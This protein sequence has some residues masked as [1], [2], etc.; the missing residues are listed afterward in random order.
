[1]ISPPWSI[2]IPIGAV[3]LTLAMLCAGRL[4]EAA[5]PPLRIAVD[6]G[7]SIAAPGAMS[8]RGRVEH[9]F[10]REL[11]REIVDALE[12]IDV[13]AFLVGDRGDMDQLMQDR[14][15]TRLNSSHT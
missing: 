6:V 13:K 15:S 5:S 2:R 4:A 14:K 7:H 10:N 3:S 8:A 11:A 1:M 9:E 12:E